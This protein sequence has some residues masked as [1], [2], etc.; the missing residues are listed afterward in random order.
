MI[1]AKK[2]ASWYKIVEIFQMP[3]KTDVNLALETARISLKRLI[4]DFKALLLKHIWSNSIKIR[5]FFFQYLFNI[6]I[7]LYSTY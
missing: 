4:Y 3:L 5:A 7:F 2:N 6:E 1:F